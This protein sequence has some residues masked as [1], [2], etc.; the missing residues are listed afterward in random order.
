MFWTCIRPLPRVFLPFKFNLCID[1]TIKLQS[2]HPESLKLSG[3]N[4]IDKSLMTSFE[5][6]DCPIGRV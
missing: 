6:F 5:L 4:D 2:Q 3:A 1:M